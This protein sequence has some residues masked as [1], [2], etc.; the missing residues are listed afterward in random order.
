M[1]EIIAVMVTSM[2]AADRAARV[3]VSA[4]RQAVGTEIVMGEP[5]VSVERN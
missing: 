1:A 5:Y 4:R 2:R 3:L